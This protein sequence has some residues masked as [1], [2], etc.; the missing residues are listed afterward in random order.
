MSRFLHGQAHKPYEI[1]GPYGL[2]LELNSNSDGIHMVFCQGTGIL[3]FLDLIDYL[4]KRTL[5][6]ILYDQRGKDIA[7][8]IVY[9]EEDY[10]ST[11]GDDFSLIVHGAFEDEA[12]FYGL[13]IV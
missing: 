9:N 2:G 5:Y 8:A 10:R 7:S 3:P 11:F 6:N 13:P 12:H 1:T 4:L